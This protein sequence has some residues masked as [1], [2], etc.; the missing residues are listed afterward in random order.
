MQ[1]TPLRTPAT[2]SA[3]ALPHPG[4]HIDGAA[5]ARFFDMRLPSGMAHVFLG[6]A[7]VCVLVI[8]GLIG[9]GVHYLYRGEIVRHAEAMA[10]SVA[11]AVLEQ[12]RE[13]LLRRSS[14]GVV[15]VALGSE[16]APAFDKRV[17]RL[18]R[19]FGIYKMRIL[20]AG[21]QPVYGTDGGQPGRAEGADPRVGAVLATGQPRLI[22][23]RRAQVTNLAGSVRLNAEVAETWLPIQVSGRTVGVF[24]LHLDISRTHEEIG[25]LFVLSLLVVGLVLAAAFAALYWPMRR[26]TARLGAVLNELH[27]LATTDPLTG[28]LNRRS[29][30]AL[31][32]M[33]AQA[34]GG[35]DSGAV[36]MVDIDH[37]KTINDAHGHPAGDEVLRTVSAVLR[38]S[39][40]QGDLI[41]RYGGEEFMVVLP[42]ARLNEAAMVAE[43]LR[44]AVAA[45]T[46]GAAGLGRAVTVSIGI[47]PWHH[48]SEDILD[49]VGRADQGL[50][51]AKAEGRDCVRIIAEA[52]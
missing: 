7:T 32:Q 3:D 2:R 40:R 10:G 41:G 18:L 46:F 33:Q 34:H 20:D 43:R 29:L 31:A 30:I 51:R 50:Y 28:T 22:P 15:S 39:L 14:T 52:A 5:L 45:T 42:G 1:S 24:E 16:A 17:R 48:A 49:A 21:G 9:V 8:T 25:R 11:E 35:H 13:T 36:I 27:Q 23:G 6:L 19:P 44:R 37:F 26:G 12:E 38:G 4:R 47:S